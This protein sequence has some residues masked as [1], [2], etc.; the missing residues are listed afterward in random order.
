VAILSSVPEKGFA[1]WDGTSMAAPHIT[2]LAALVLAHH[3][4]FRTPELQARSGARVD[5]L[6]QILKA[7]ATPVVLGDTT[8]TGAGL[9]DAPRALGLDVAQPNAIQL[10][11]QMLADLNAAMAQAGLA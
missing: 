5:R 9:P 6:F 1:A 2:G 7:S 3:P 8:R 10:V 4:D 11:Q